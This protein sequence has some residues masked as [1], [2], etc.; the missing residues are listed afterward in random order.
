MHSIPKFHKLFESLCAIVIV[1]GSIVMRPIHFV[2][3]IL[4]PQKKKC[5]ISEMHI[6]PF[7]DLRQTE[8][9]TLKNAH[10]YKLFDKLNERAHA[11]PCDFYF[12]GSVFLQLFVQRGKQYAP[13]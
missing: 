1:Y 10:Y 7:N 9:I 3:E 2:D 13:I 8:K 4:F 11:I 6:N 5:D 12:V